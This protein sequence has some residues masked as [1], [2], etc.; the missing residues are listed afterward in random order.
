MMNP[1]GQSGDAQSFLM[2]LLNALFGGQG[3][4]GNGGMP[5]ATPGWTPPGALGGGAPM[6]G[7]APTSGVPQ[8]PKMN[9]PGTIDKPNAGPQPIGQSPYAHFRRGLPRQ[10]Q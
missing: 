7:Q 9:L 6:G 1:N 3:G 2:N 4:M 8:L 10:G 5:G